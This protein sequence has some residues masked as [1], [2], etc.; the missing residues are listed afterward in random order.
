MDDKIRHLLQL[1]AH[2]LSIPFGGGAWAG[3]KYA[4]VRVHPDAPGRAGLCVEY[5]DGTVVWLVAEESK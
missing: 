1:C 2:S 3:V 5:E 4:E